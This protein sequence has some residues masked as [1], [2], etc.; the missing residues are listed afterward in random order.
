MH[1]NSTN[2]ALDRI[3]NFF[4]EERHTQLLMDLSLN[5]K[6]VISQRLL[7]KVGDSGCV[8][9]V[10][11]MLNTPLMADLISKGE[12]HEIR[13]LIA[14]SNEAGMQPFD[15]HLFRLLEDG[16]IT[17]EDALRNAIA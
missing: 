15:Q 5:L 7:P 3:I 11:I 10:E 2:Q 16:L 12:A 8:R 14:R 9:A 13:S 1:A 6:A 17:Y 4:P